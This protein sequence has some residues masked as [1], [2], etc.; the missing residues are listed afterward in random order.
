[1]FGRLSLLQSLR[2]SSLVSSSAADRRPAQ[3]ISKIETLTS[4][5]LAL[6]FTISAL[7]DQYAPGAGAYCPVGGGPY[8][9]GPGDA[10]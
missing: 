10:P 9:G 3:F 4:L 1:M 2:A 8:G 7:A 6:S 5:R